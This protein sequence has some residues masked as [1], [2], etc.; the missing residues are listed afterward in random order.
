[1]LSILTFLSIFFGF[2]FK[3]Q[4]IG[5]GSNFFGNSLSNQASFTDAEF[6]PS[7]IK[8]M[9]LGI[10]I[11]VIFFAYVISINLSLYS[12]NSYIKS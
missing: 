2:I 3:D 6:L 12:V 5:L 9:P 7:Y 1:M 8:L 11:L 10:S 4:F